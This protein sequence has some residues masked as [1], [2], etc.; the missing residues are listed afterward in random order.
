VSSGIPIIRLRDVL[1]VAIQVDP[2]DQVLRAMREELAHEIERIDIRGV[3]VEVSGIGCFDSFIAMSIRD[4]AQMAR[5]MGATT[6]VAGLDP[7]I[8]ITLVELGMTLDRVLTA[9]DLE[10]AL[11]LLSARHE[12][13]DD[14][15]LSLDDAD[16]RDELLLRFPA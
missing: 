15:A 10:S 11:A 12:D 9:R 14:E 1:L 16:A 3:V 5:L 6:V 2:T 4:T 7:G 8:A 13:E